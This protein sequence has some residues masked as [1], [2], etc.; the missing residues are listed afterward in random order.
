MNH[1][2]I[3][4]EKDCKWHLWSWHLW[5]PATSSPGATSSVRS[6]LTGNDLR[7][8][9]ELAVVGEGEFFFDVHFLH[10]HQARR[11]P[12]DKPLRSPELVVYPHHLEG[13]MSTRAHTGKE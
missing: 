5:S 9:L 12:E 7:I 6:F 10:H 3:T 4:Q 13:K 11:S 1:H 8:G 2:Y